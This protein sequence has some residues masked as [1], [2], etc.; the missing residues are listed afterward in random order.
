MKKL[1]ISIL[2]AIN[3]MSAY[4]DGG[5]VD[6]C[7]GVSL[8]PEQAAIL[9]E[10][11]KVSLSA[12]GNASQANGTIIKNSVS[13]FSTVANGSTD[14]AVLP[15]VAQMQR[16]SV[17]VINASSTGTLLVF[18]PSGGAI[19]GGSTNASVAV[20]PN[21][22]AIFRRTSS[23]NWAADLSARV[24]SSIVIPT[25]GYESVAG[26]GTTVADAAALSASKHIHQ[27]TGA[28]GTVGWKFSTGL[29]IGQVEIL[30]GT[31]AGVAKVYGESGSTCNGGATDA[32]CT[33]TTGILPHICYKTAALTYICA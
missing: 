27:I 4:A 3:T 25:S 17:T 26:A 32:A 6:E 20:A 13:S 29:P 9:C 18:P 11:R 21:T 1:L 15:T 23:L 19:N 2:L 33:L 24:D 31:T 22:A 10:Q 28:D 7:S 5:T 12:A 16:D 30:L 8:K 14:S